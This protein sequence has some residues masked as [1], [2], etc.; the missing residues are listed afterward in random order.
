MRAELVE[1]AVQ[2]EEPPAREQLPSLI[3]TARV[4]SAS[5]LANGDVGEIDVSSGLFFYD[6]AYSYCSDPREVRCVEP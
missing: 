6:Y 5:S 2:A 3:L 4:Q 1:A